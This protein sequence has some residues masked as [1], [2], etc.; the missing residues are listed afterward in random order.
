MAT[1]S[2]PNPRASLL[3]GLRTGGV[4]S[5]SQPQVP[6]TAAI[7]GSFSVPR[8]ASNSHPS[9]S[10]PEER[11]E[12]DEL[13]D[14]A[15]HSLSF[16]GHN[17]NSRQV[18]LTAAADG[19]VNNFQQQQQQLIMRQLAAQRASMAGGMPYAANGD[20]TEMQAQ[21]M[22]MEMLKYQVSSRMFCS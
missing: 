5:A 19:S 13:S 8:L 18:P 11:D 12:E 6:H 7:T 1:A 14:I 9:T 17:F 22:Q 16:N 15:A 10:F 21:M 3:S 2:T 20:Q 4:R